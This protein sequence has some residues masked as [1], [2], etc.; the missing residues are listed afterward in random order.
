MATQ[1]SGPV[2]I[3]INLD[4]AEAERKLEEFKKKLPE[5]Q[6]ARGSFRSNLPASP[7]AA[8]EVKGPFSREARREILWNKIGKYSRMSNVQRWEFL[9]REKERQKVAKTA[10]DMAG[11]DFSKTNAFTSIA[12]AGLS[13]GTGSALK[14]VPPSILKLL[15]FAAFA[16]KAAVAYGIFSQTVKTLPAAAGLGRQLGGEPLALTSTN[17][18]ATV[19][20]LQ[21]L[22]EH[23]R[24][25]VVDLETKVTSMFT[26]MSTTADVNTAALRITG[27]LADSKKYFDMFSFADQREGKLQDRFETW[28]SREAPFVT[29][30]TIV[31]SVR[32]GLNR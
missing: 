4:F 15:G 7:A 3:P 8:P 5:K 9:L 25:T 27:K 16:S 14:A 31:D 24:K 19:D 2:W 26:G 1:T 6:G 28:K 23:L 12:R 13:G 21:G 18:P 20:Q 10:D 30:R 32:R 11:T 29:I 22:V 17:T